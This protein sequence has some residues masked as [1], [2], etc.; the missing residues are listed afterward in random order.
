MEDR[1]CILA[2]MESRSNAETLS[3][4]RVEPTSATNGGAGDRVAT[5]LVSLH[6]GIG[7][8]H[9]W[10]DR[11]LDHDPQCAR[12]LCVRAAARLLA[13]DRPG[14]DAARDAI[15]AFERLSEPPDPVARRHI[16]AARAW[17][18]GD[19]RGALGHYERL[20][21]EHPD[22][23]L[24]LHMALALDFRFGRREMLRDRVAR[25]L[26]HWQPAMPAYGR[27][28]AMY[29]FGLEETGD[30]AR[31]EAIAHASLEHAPDNAPAMHVVAHVME[32]QG[33]AREGI[34]WLEA[35][36]ASWVS[37][38]GYGMHLAWHLALLHLD[39]DD[40][41]S[42][43]GIYDTLL[44]PT[45]TSTTPALVDATALLW[46]LA[47]RGIPLQ[48]RARQ[49]ARCWKRKPLSG[50]RTFNLVHAAT[51]F[52]AA[53]R[54]RLVKRVVALLRTDAPTRAVNE[55]DDLALS[56]AVCAAIQAFAR[57]DFD[58]CVEQITQIRADAARCGG[59]VAQCDLIDLTLIE[60]ALRAHRV[61][62]ARS[63][64][65][66]RTTRKPRS[67]LNRWLFARAAAAS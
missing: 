37:N 58:R 2:A 18:A 17:N 8:V 39:N 1:A 38:A 23:D 45:S 52:A 9:A 11:A 55:P 63:L 40:A 54:H 51:A 7:D 65:Q 66:E 10:I 42:A 49:L 61:R 14:D 44:Q 24:A 41:A 19:F 47:L 12:A 64:A 3:I 27:V 67:R 28:L 48:P 29:A 6:G 56:T 43:L 57:G 16:D 35:R 5:A 22:D 15:D 53:G 60:A 26:P 59:S 31:A 34:D 32:M 20:L 33:R 4:E 30:Y 62:L 36:R 46:R 13:A 50:M 25:V 21:A